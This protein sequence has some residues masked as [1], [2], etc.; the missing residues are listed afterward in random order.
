MTEVTPATAPTASELRNRAAR[1]KTAGT[2]GAK[3]NYRNSP[4]YKKAYADEMRAA[5]KAAAHARYVR[6][7]VAAKIAKADAAK[8]A[9]LAAEKAAG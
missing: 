3:Q 6:D 4:A 8:K 2:S 9:R 1:A 7:G 5:G